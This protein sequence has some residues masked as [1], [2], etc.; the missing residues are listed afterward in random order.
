MTLFYGKVNFDPLGIG[1]G[2]AEKLFFCVA[3]VL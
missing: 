3:F 2:K 1:M